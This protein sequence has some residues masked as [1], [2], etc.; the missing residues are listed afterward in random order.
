MLWRTFW[1]ENIIPHLSFIDSL[2]QMRRKKIGDELRNFTRRWESDKSVNLI[3]DNGSAINSVAQE[4]IDKLNLPTEKLPKPYQVT[5]YVIPVTHGCLVSFKIGHYGD[6]I[7]CDVLHMNIAHILF[8]CPWLF[9]WKVHNDKEMNTNFSWN[10]KRIRLLPMKSTDPSSSTSSPST[11]EPQ[12]E[13]KV[14][15]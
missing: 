10:G 13:Q 4:V 12:K 5:C 3:I 14:E 7:W 2:I 15:R 1:Q 11:E 9:N 6:K 8:G